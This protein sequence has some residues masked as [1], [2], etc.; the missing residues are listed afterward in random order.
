MSKLQTIRRHGILLAAA[1]AVPTFFVS[2]RSSAATDTWTGGGGNPNW[3]TAGNW[4]TLPV[5]NDILQFAGTTNLITNNDFAAN[6]QFNGINFLSG[7][8]AFTLGGNAVLLGGDINQNSN[9]NQTISLPL[10][11][12]GA[13]STIAGT[14]TGSL[15]IGTLT[16]GLAAQS[17][18]VSTLNVNKSV[19]GT[20][21]TVRTNNA[22]A[23]AVTIAA[24]QALTFNG[25]AVANNAIVVIGTPTTSATAVPT[26][27]TVSGAGNFTTTTTNGNFVVAVGSGNNNFGRNNATL[28][29]SAMTGNFTYNTGTAG[30]GNFYIGFATRPEATVRLGTGT[31]TIV[32]AT[33]V[34]G[35]S[36]QTPGFTALGTNNNNGANSRLFLGGGTNII[37]TGTITLG[38]T[39]GQG[40]VDWQVPGQGSVTIAGQAG[41]ATRANITVGRFSSGSATT[42][43][44]TMLL[45]GHNATV[46]AE[47]VQIGVLNG[48]TGSAPA[49]MITFDTGT[50]DVNSLQIGVNQNTASNT[51]GAAGEFRLGGDTP[52]NTAT[53]ILTVNNSFFLGNDTSTVLT[54]PTKPTF[55]VNG[56]TANINV[57]IQVVSNGDTSIDT[58]TLTVAG[59]TL[60]MT[61]HNIGSYASPVKTINLN[62]GSITNAGRINGKTINVAGAVTFTGAPKLTLAD[63]GVFNNNTGSA[64]VLP[65][66]SSIEGGGASGPSAVNGD[67][68]AGTGSRIAPGTSSVAATLAFANNLTFNTGSTAHFDLTPTPGAGNDLITVGGNLSVNGTVNLEFGAL[69][70]GA[71]VGQTYTLFTYAGALTGNETN[72]ALGSGGTRKTFTVLPTATTPGSIQVSVGGGNPLTLTYFGNINSEWDLQGDANW[73]DNANAAQQ[74]FNADSVIF[75]DNSNNNA[76]VQL[77]GDLQPTSVTVSATRNYKFVGAGSINGG[78][79]LTKGGS[80]TLIIANN[81]AYTGTTDIQSGTLQIGD[82]GTTGSLGSGAVTNN[83]AL[84]FNRTDSHTVANVISGGGTLSKNGTGTLSLT[85]A[86]TYTGATNVNAG[87]LKVSAGNSTGDTAGAAITVASGATFDIGGNLANNNYNLGAK[88]IHISGTGV[89]GTAGAI[90]NTGVVQNAAFNNITLDADALI[91]GQRID[92]GRTTAVGSRTLDLANHTLSVNMIGTNPIFSVL[93]GVTVTPGNIVAVGGGLNFE[94]SSSTPDNGGTITL[95]TGTVLQVF[96]TVDGTLARPIVLKGNNIVGSGNT[97]VGIINS[98]MSLEGNIT[99]Q[100]LASGVPSANNNPLTLSGAITESG[101]ARSITKLGVSLVTFNAANNYSGGTIISG[102]TVRLANAGTVGSGPVTNNAAFEVN[103]NNAIGDIDGTGTTTIGDGSSGLSV[104]ANHVR[105]ST[106][107]IN[108][109]TTLKINASSLAAGVSKVNALVVTAGRLDL[110]NNKLITNDPAG[111]ASG[112]IY[113]GVQGMVQTGLNGGGWDGATGIITSQPSAV[114]PAPYLSTIGV[115]TGEQVRGLG[116]TDTDTWGGQ[117]IT[118]ASTLAMWTYAGD[119]NL[120]GVINADDYANISFYDNI[121]TADGYAN[122]DFNYDGDINPDDFSLIDFNRNAQGAP[123]FN[124]GGAQGLSVTAVPEPACGFAGAAALLMLNRRRRRA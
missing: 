62:G 14:G 48:A 36:A 113:N 115:A 28:D 54:S 84:V 57:D 13:T 52:N 65:S 121:P 39:K 119:A 124:S 12:D 101:G 20:G 69:G 5:A 89:G 91:T 22:A 16:L 110:N 23:N 1:A 90:T 40:T 55:T 33:L 32:A 83:G 7:A 72:F 15:N 44:S 109:G 118:G 75:D 80:G 41:G 19:T 27:L 73:K 63:G 4:D 59:G 64:L 38:N 97:T 102:G 3:T 92:I 104:T 9:S 123:I 95:N 82:A 122:G 79:T 42:A 103:N 93:D 29:M 49:N 106:L 46:Q 71:Q 35:D 68:T 6:T 66:G 111:F 18:N 26:S 116:P 45:A 2:S 74:F 53:G 81:N 98:P 78:A 50:F 99:I 112:G 96:Q 120:D 43:N 60:N 117:T 88:V 108:S 10:L 67:I 25:P 24:G 85:G 70:G 31:N 107:T 37:N 8:G 11:L 56:G 51:N 76:D 87:T 61:N 94:R 58:N 86:S 77:I 100:A 114:S 17:V 21:F 30:T 47:T 34:I 105:Q